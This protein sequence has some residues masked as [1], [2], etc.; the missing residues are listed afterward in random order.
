MK[1]ITYLIYVIFW[2]SL[3]I[4][5]CAYLVFWRG[6][7]PWWWA[8]AVLLS[9]G[10]ARPSTWAQLFQPAAA[11]EWMAKEGGRV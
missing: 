6:V 2:E 9:C 3:C 5:G 10:T 11:R 7:N 8:L 4:G 1:A